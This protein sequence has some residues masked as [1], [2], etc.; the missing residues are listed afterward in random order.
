[1]N[2]LHPS[3]SESFALS[4]CSR[5][6]SKTQLWDIFARIGT[7]KCI[8][9]SNHD[10]SLEE[11]SHPHYVTYFVRQR[12]QKLTEKVTSKVPFRELSWEDIHFCGL[13]KEAFN[14]RKI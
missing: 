10:G 6:L 8:V 1:M 3:L 12:L 14:R 9:S 11:I 4:I 2:V 13:K 5:I 7:A